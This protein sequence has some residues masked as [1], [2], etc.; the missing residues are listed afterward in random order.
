MK[1][2]ARF[3]AWATLTFAAAWLVADPWQHAIAGIAGSIVAGPGRH[4]EWGTIE[5]FFPFDLSVYAA[6]CLSSAWAGW[7]ERLRALSLGALVIVV[8]EIVT[9]VVV[10]KVMLSA[11]NLPPDRQD[12]T[13]RLIV[14]II[15]LTGLAVAGATWMLTLGWQGVA[16][17]ARRLERPSGSTDRRHS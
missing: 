17:F 10:M 1:P 7:N 12:A 15:R 5:V 9:L 11:A 6:L 2:L 3:A 16:P 14:A 8:I 4:I 13:Q